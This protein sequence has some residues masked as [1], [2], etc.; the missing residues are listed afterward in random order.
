LWDD[1]WNHVLFGDES[2]FG[3]VRSRQG[4]RYLQRFIQGTVPFRS[5][6]IMV[7]GDV[8]LGG[9][10][11][12]YICQRTINGNTCANDIVNGILPNFQA[13]IGPHFIYIDDNARPHLNPI[14]HVWDALGNALHNYLPPPEIT[15]D[16]SNI[17]PLHCFS[18]GFP[19]L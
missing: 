2:C 11:D 5:G 15:R 16:L 9:R 8:C 19:L 10:T 4:E 3:R 17:L 6:S 13:T 12:L 14:E 18:F 1:E 7:W